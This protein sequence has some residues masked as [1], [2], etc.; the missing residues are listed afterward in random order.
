MD[1]SHVYGACR[2]SKDGANTILQKQFPGGSLSLVGAN[3]PRGVGNY[4]HFL[5]EERLLALG[6]GAVQLGCEFA[7]LD[8]ETVLEGR[9]CTCLVL[10]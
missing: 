2:K 4:R 3:S 6:F 1:C 9:R 5:G 10:D 8:A 7:P